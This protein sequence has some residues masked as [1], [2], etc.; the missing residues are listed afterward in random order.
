MVKG[1][2]K[3]EAALQLRG[4]RWVRELGGDVGVNGLAS[5]KNLF[6]KCFPTFPFFLGESL[7]SVYVSR[8]IT[9]GKEGGRRS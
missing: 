3:E 6:T 1:V 2:S 8:N 7:L 4:R 9:V 5:A